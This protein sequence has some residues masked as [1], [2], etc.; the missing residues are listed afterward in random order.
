MKPAPSIIALLLLGLSFSA[1][2]DQSSERLDRL[3]AN[4]QE[5]RDAEEAAGITR[6]IWQAWHETENEKVSALM[7]EGV[8]ALV[9]RRFAM[10]LDR[11]TRVTHAAPDF[12]EG[13][14]KLA[15]VNF[16]L[17]NLEASAKQVEKTLA[18]EPRHFGA[19]SGRGMI[20]LAQGYPFEAASDF[21]R[22]LEINPFLEELR[23][24]VEALERELIRNTVSAPQ[25]AAKQKA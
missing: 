24:R 1:G 16:H 9:H 6:D 4:L 22:A 23:D 15:T 13:W 5:T 2:A 25:N 17:G 8:T 3:F 11:F 10:A 20:R 21:R 19:I 14:N 12:A 18:L 7:N